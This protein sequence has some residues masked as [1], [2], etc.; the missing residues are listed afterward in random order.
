M[1]HLRP[2]LVEL[3][4][5]ISKEKANDK[6]EQANDNAKMSDA[7]A[8]DL[9]QHSDS[10]DSDT[11]NEEL[12]L[13]PDEKDATSE[14]PAEAKRKKPKSVV[15]QVHECALRMKMNVEFEVRSYLSK[16]GF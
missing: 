11:E 5:K 13:Y 9:F 2:A 6:L 8:I 4:N 14:P 3:E 10:S 12:D 7:I 16:I 15:S 1:F